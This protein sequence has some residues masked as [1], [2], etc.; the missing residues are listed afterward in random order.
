MKFNSEYS[1][2]D[3]GWHPGRNITLVVPS[4]VVKSLLQLLYIQWLDFRIH[5]IG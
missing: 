4:L 3:Q 2:L 1:Y 5:W